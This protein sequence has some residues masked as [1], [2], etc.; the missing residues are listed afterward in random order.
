MTISI[1]DITESVTTRKL[2]WF[3]S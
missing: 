3:W 1:N 2:L